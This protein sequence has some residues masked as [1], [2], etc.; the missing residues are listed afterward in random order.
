MQCEES[1]CLF[2]NAF[3]LSRGFVRPGGLPTINIFQNTQPNE[4]I[5]GQK[6][7]SPRKATVFQQKSNV[8]RAS[9]WK[10]FQL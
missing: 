9:I 5:L 10:Y 4:I 2:L 1:A 8:T 3:G 6:C 7:S